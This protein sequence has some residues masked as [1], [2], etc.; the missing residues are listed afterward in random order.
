[1]EIVSGAE[2]CYQ[3]QVTCNHTCTGPDAWGEVFEPCLGRFQSPINIVTRRVLPD[4]R[5][6]PFHFTGYQETFHTNLTNNGH[7]VQMDLP[8]TIKI[9][10]GK[11][12]GPYKAIQL[13]LHWG[14]EGGPGSEHMIDG[15]QFPMEM[16]IV[17]IKDEYDTLSQ[18]VGDPSGV[19]VL[20]FFFQEG[21]SANK[22]FDP[23]INALKNITQPSKSTMLNGVSLGMFI[24]PEENLTKYFRYDGSLTTP[25][26][27]EAVVWTLF[28]NVILLSRKQL[29]AFSQLQVSSGE[30]MVK[31][32]RPVQP[33]HG[34]QVYYSRGHVALVSAGLIIMSMLLSNT[35]SLHTAV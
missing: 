33:L 28:E 13:H 11:L 18:A 17:H 26:C 15:E 25:N 9:E 30:R 1:M 29:A 31:T 34:R 6:T 4:D 35:P 23:L 12:A 3:S 14:K 24:P 5:L 19:A 16:H 2:W 32:Y 10:G 8:S 22:K 7:T 20:G 21:T 27:D